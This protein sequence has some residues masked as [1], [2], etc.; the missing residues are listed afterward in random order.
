[1]QP[2][3]LIGVLTRLPPKTRDATHALFFLLSTPCSP[4][5]EIYRKQFAWMPRLTKKHHC[6]LSLSL[7]LSILQIH[8]TARWDRFEASPLHPPAP[9]TFLCLA[10]DALTMN[11]VDCLI[12]PLWRLVVILSPFRGRNGPAENLAEQLRKARIENT[13]EKSRF[14]I[15]RQTTYEL[16]NECTI[17]EILAQHIDCQRVLQQTVRKTYQRG[18]VLFAILVLVGKEA[19]IELFF[20]ENIFDDKLPLR[21]RFQDNEFNLWAEDRVLVTATGHWESRHRENF[22][23]FQ[24]WFLATVFKDLKHYELHDDASLPTLPLLPEESHLVTQSGGFSDV[25]FVRFHPAQ[26]EWS[27]VIDPEVSIHPYNDMSS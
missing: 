18:K 10:L 27:E 7:S 12:Y 5:S 17:T 22:C 3:L 1:M 13:V 6:S 24:W 9:T 14:Y 11:L 26:M 15:P 25:L 4:N 8:M 23:S 19:E 21:R 2:I 20:R 16:I